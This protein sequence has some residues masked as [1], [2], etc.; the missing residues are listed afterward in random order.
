[1]RF[2]T[3]GDPARPAAVMIHGM[4]CSNSSCA[5][6]ARFLQDKYYVILPTLDSHHP[7]SAPLR[8]AGQ[9]TETLLDWLGRERIGSLALLHGTSMGAEIALAA[10]VRAAV[11]ITR[12]V[13]DSGP[14]FRFPR[15]VRAV[16]ARKFWSIAQHC[17]GKAPQAVMQDPLLR[18]LSGDN[19]KQ[20]R[21]LWGAVCEVSGY[22]TAEDCRAMAEICYGGAL[23]AF[24][25][26][27]Q[28]RFTFLFS[29]GEPAHA[30]KKRLLRTYPAASYIDRPGTVHCG[31]QVSD[32]EGCAAFLKSLIV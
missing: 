29:E 9:Q 16:M 21:A 22:L 2:E 19:P 14:F 25:E 11:P 5:R 31:F 7:G 8:S 15:P 30:S 13:F 28:R 20:F 23:P 1:M 26:G 3:T 18:R 17:R 6:F 27:Q 10:A 32:P 4:F 12:C 24:S